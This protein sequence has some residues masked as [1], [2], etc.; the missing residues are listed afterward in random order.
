MRRLYPTGVL[1]AWRWPPVS[2][3]SPQAAPPRVRLGGVA[4]ER[5][6]DVIVIGAGI[7]GLSAARAAAAAGADVIVL[8]KSRGFGGRCASRTV[9]GVRVDH[10]AQFVSVRDARFQRQVDAWLDD[11]TM[12]V[13]THGLTRWTAAEGWRDGAASGHPRYACPAGMNALGKTLANG[14][15]VER[16][17][18][19]QRL[20]PSSAGWVASSVDGR[21]WRA[22][23]VI[24]SAPVPQALALIAPEDGDAAMRHELATLT[25]EPCHAVVAHYGPQAV[26]GFDAL[27]LPE[28]AD[29]A[30]I[31]NDSSRRGA[32]QAPG[33]T[34]VL[35]ATPSFTRA[36]FAASS[37][38]II[39]RLLSAAAHVLPWA[40]APEW[41][42]HH[43]WRFA[44]PLRTS[45][46]PFAR[47]SVGLTLCGDA[48]G[49]GRVEGAYLSG[50]AAAT[51][52]G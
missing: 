33:T 18:Q 38:T 50:L 37:S 21:N 9:N 10:G 16:E 34:L 25:Y 30:W 19:V 43:R 6:S 17:V 3:R 51:G 8:E 4:T 23:Q 52:S 45:Q 22:A 47:L 12:Q 41:T 2:R 28:H 39:E 36:E 13:W 40:T 24:V 5:S 46:R 42:T 44:R 20:R 49:D 32:A 31:A 14:L 7:A 15:T 11:G 35:H 26:V 1:G 48:F 29:L 27:Q